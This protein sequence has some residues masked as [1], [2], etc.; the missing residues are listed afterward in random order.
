MKF[1]VVLLAVYRHA[2]FN[3]LFD[4]I[5]YCVTASMGF[6]TLENIAYVVSG[7]LQV[8]IMRALLS[9]PGHAF[10]A[11]LMGYYVGIAKFTDRDETRWL[12]QGL[13]LAA[14]AHAVFDAVI[15]TQTAL[16]LASIPLVA[17][18]GGAPLCSPAGF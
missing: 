16:A 10:F 7:G 14:L 1:A 8:G 13:L 17:L 11:S 4:G 5:I 9:V 6:A 3:E 15:L 12:I 2:E 18:F